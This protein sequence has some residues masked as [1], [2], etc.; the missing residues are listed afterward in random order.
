MSYNNTA[1]TLAKTASMLRS[2]QR[3]FNVEEIKVKED[4]TVTGNLTVEGKVVFEGDLEL[5]DT[6]WDDLKAP[7]TAINPPGI[8]S[9]PDFDTTY[10]GWLFNASG[11]ELLWIILQMPHDYKE[12]SAIRPHVHWYP[13]STNT[14][15]VYWRMEYK[16]TNVN[17]TDAGTFTTL[18][19]LDAG[20]GTAYKHQVV[21]FDEIAGTGKKISSLLII[22]FSRQG[23]EGTDTYT[24]DALFREFD[25]HYQKDGFGS[26]EEYV[27]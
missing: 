19:V 22:K 18:N 1:N 16:W 6:V 8:A 2:R 27:K 7:A 10:G 12:G 20:D 4:L 24:G 5:E 9:D 14:G 25:V 13:I 3:I 26:D 23:S 17:D 11:V 21:N 15:D